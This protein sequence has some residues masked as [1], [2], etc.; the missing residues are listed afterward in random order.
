VRIQGSEYYK[1]YTKNIDKV[2]GADKNCK[3]SDVTN[4]L[5]CGNPT[6][7]PMIFLV[8]SRFDMY[9]RYVQEQC[10][11]LINVL[12]RYRINYYLNILPVKGH[13]ILMGPDQAIDLI[14]Q[15][16]DSIDNPFTFEEA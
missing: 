13:L 8:Q 9:D 11:H 12:N 10:F 3:L 2:F 14:E 16:K 4:L 1:Q 5:D 15:F 6:A 7:N